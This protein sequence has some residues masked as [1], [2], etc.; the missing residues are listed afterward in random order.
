MSSFQKMTEFERVAILPSLSLDEMAK[1][2][3]GIPI[4]TLKRD[5]DFKTISVIQSI[6]MYIKRTLEEIFKISTIERITKYTEYKPAPHPV[7]DNEKIFS[8][9]IF[10]IG[11][12]CSDIETTPTPILERCK[13]A[14]INLALNNKQKG[15]LSLIGG[16]SAELAAEQLKNNR[17]IYK[18]DEELVNINKLLGISIHLLALEKY[19]QNTSKWIKNDDSVCVEHIKEI[20]DNYISEHE[21]ST[22]GLKSS[23]LRAKLSYALKSIHD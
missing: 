19:K 20:I 6:K 7:D 16:L 13:S 22:D 5:I 15:V 9:L 23:S 21:I 3:V 14:V 1:C 8:D 2:L 18:K 12:N 11:Y 10:A 4:A 17:G